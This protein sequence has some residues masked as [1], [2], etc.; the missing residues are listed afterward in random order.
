M[1]EGLLL[2]L[3]NDAN[4]IWEK[5]PAV[6]VPKRM[7]VTGQVV[8][9]A[10]KLYWMA[11]NPSAGNSA[12]ELTDAIVALAAVAF[13]HFDVSREGH[14]LLL[15]PPMPF[16]TGIYLETLTNMTSVIFGYV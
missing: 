14:M 7:V 5:A 15:S 3:W 4:N 16:S 2:W 1:G 8:A 6:V 10:H 12:I 13:D 11:L 9:G